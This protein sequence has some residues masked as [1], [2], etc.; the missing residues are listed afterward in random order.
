MNA[1]WLPGRVTPQGVL[2]RY[3]SFSNIVLAGMGSPSDWR[4][5]DP[6][7]NLG[8]RCKRP[9]FMPTRS[10]AIE[11]HDDRGIRCRVARLFFGRLADRPI[12]WH[13]GVSSSGLPMEPKRYLRHRVNAVPR[14]AWSRSWV[15]FAHVLVPV[16]SSVQATTSEVAGAAVSK[17]M[18]S[19]QSVTEYQ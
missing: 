9:S 8:K 4:G 17:W 7:L 16:R 3:Y 18:H 19:P 2:N 11:F 1:R 14:G 13:A 5:G 6:Q 10:A 12:C 15:R